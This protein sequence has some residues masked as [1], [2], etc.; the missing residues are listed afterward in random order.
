MQFMMIA[1]LFLLYETRSIENKLFFSK[2]NLFIMLQI[3]GLFTFYVQKTIMYIY[4]LI[5]VIVF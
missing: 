3:I 2:N 4:N 5:F 1:K